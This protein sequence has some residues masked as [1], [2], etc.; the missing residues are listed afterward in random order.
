MTEKKKEKN[1]W[2]FWF[3]VVLVLLILSWGSSASTSSD[4]LYECEKEIRQLETQASDYRIEIYEL[5][6]KISRLG[7]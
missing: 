6:E 5:K 1:R 3:W 2:K 4:E 7:G